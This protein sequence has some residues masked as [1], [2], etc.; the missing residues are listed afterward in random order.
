MV[1]PGWGW[2]AHKEKGLTIISRKPLKFLV[3][4]DRIELT[5]S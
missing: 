1:G 3:E 4:V 5:A 2:K